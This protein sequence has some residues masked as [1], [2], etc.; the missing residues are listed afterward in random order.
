MRLSVV[1]PTATEETGAVIDRFIAEGGGKL[2]D[3]LTMVAIGETA[4]AAGVT[5][6]SEAPPTPADEDFGVF[7]S[8]GETENPG[9]SFRPNSERGAEFNG[10]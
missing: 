5:N 10:E 8:H 3:V 1:T 7:E 4:A 2:G 6:K 9:D